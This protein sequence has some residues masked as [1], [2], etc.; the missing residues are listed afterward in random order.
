M[1]QAVIFDM[2]GLLINS[3]PFWQQSEIEVFGTVGV[4]LTREMCEQMMGLRIDE[5]VQHWYDYQLWTGPSQEEIKDKIIDRLIE[6]IG[7]SG[8][9]MDGVE[10]I[11]KFFGDKG[12]KM[13]I[14]SSSNLRIIEYVVDKFG[15]A[16]HFELIHS[17]EL[18]KYGKPHPDIFIHTAHKMSVNPVDCLVFEDSFNG[19]VAAKAARMKVVMIPEPNA[20]PQTR[21][22]IG[23]FKLKNLN[24]FGEE[25]WNNLLKK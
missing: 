18:E 4:N 20:Y 2:D 10:Y 22:D 5:V 6:L 1:P 11:L 17:A 12:V 23:D 14:A 24:E 3:E 7:E 13:S 25:E 21:F 15:L 19:L 8:Q 16:K 9:L